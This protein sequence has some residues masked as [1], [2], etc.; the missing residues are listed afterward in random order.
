MVRHQSMHRRISLKR[1]ANT[2]FQKTN[3]VTPQP[4]FTK[5]AVPIKQ[6]MQPQRRSAMDFVNLVHEFQPNTNMHRMMERSIQLISQQPQIPRPEEVKLEDRVAEIQK[7]VTNVTQLHHRYKEESVN[8]HGNSSSGNS[9]II[10]QL[11]AIPAT[12]FDHTLQHSPPTS[13]DFQTSMISQDS[14][15]AQ[16]HVFSDMDHMSPSLPSRGGML[17]Q[18]QLAMQP[19]SPVASVVSPSSSMSIQSPIPHLSVGSAMTPG[20]ISGGVHGVQLALSPMANLS[21]LSTHSPV[22]SSTTMRMSSSSAA[23]PT[24][25]TPQHSSNTISLPAAALAASVLQRNVLLG[26]TQQRKL[27]R[28]KRVRQFESDGIPQVFESA[29][30]ESSPSSRPR[31]STSSSKRQSS[32]PR[33]TTSAPAAI[34]DADSTSDEGNDAGAKNAASNK[35]VLQCMGVNRKKRIRC[36]NPALMEYIGPRPLYCAEHISLDTNCLYHKCP[37]SYQKTPGDGKVGN[38]YEFVFSFAASLYLVFF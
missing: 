23:T 27:T 17:S 28:K 9:H 15:S 35:S 5:T 21:T 24:P 31:I 7:R 22:L 18:P 12:G 14:L 6:G 29:E 32:A 36:R 1:F 19:L 3:T 10:S 30:A 33:K 38:Y 8:T 13:A 11:G 37:S 2:I 20:P 4:P 25:S 26:G 16:P 34:S